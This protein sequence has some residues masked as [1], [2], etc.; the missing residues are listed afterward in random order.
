MKNCTIVLILV[1]V[2]LVLGDR[3]GGTKGY[4]TKV[5]ILVV[6]ELVLGVKNSRELEHILQS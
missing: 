1:V 4:N 6:V 2:E 5:L 3:T